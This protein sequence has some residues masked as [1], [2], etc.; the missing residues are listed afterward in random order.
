MSEHSQSIVPPHILE[1]IA[2]HGTDE[3]QQMARET[4][5]KSEEVRVGESGTTATR[6]WRRVDHPAAH[7]GPHQP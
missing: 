4:L 3:Q 7:P 2:E 1:S 5:E 6:G